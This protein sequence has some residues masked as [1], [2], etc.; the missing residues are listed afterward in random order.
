MELKIY[1]DG[2]ARGNPGPAGAGIVFCDDKK[3]IKHKISRY[4]GEMTNNQAEYRAV[5]I[6]LDHL[7]ENYKDCEVEFYLDSQLIVEQLNQRYK[8]KNQGLKPL[9]WEIRE[10]ILKL[11]GKI[12]FEFVPREENREADKLVN[13]A[14]ENLN[15]EK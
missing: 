8:I 6:A 1:T 2:G 5:I 11:G 7:L 3:Q 4:L 10:K 15:Q 12:N 9:F 14:I 13:K